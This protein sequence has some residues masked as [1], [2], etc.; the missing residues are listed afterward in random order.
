[1]FPTWINGDF[2]GEFDVILFTSDLHGLCCL[3]YGCL[4]TAKG[5]G[6]IR[7]IQQ[8][9]G[10]QFTY[11]V[12]I[13]VYVAPLWLYVSAA[14]HGQTSRT[15]SGVDRVREAPPSRTPSPSVGSFQDM[16]ATRPRQEVSPMQK[17]T[18]STH[19]LP[20]PHRMAPPAIREKVVPQLQVPVV[21]YD[22]VIPETEADATSDE[23]L[24]RE[25]RTKSRNDVQWED[26]V[27]CGDDEV[28]GRLKRKKGQQRT[29]PAVREVHIN[30]QE[31]DGSQKR[32]T[33]GSTSRRGPQSQAASDFHGDT[34]EFSSDG[35]DDGTNSE[36]DY[37]NLPSMSQLAFKPKESHIDRFLRVT[38]DDDDRKT[39]APN[40]GKKLPPAGRKPVSTRTRS[41]QRT[42]P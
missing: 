18:P 14:D 11:Y 13:S 29:E 31:G 20:H 15:I 19:S 34:V 41:S 2:K 22:S 10:L 7:A 27:P 25:R 16:A 8:G 37:Q 39:S 23:M 17:A 35:D 1:M 12:M 40:K 33:N 32:K 3:G 5:N 30:F 9:W 36:D 38:G 4:M 24:F 21:H 42:K 6:H 26:R 28:N